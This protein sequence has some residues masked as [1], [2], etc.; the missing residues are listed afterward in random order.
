MLLGMAECRIP[1]LG[2]F[3]LDLVFRIIFLYGAYLLY[4]L[5]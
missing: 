4:S 3:D 2:H 1:F 5:R